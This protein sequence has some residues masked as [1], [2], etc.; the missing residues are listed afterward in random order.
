MV[1][2]HVGWMGPFLPEISRLASVSIDRAGLIISAASG[3]YFIALIA[4]G[5]M[6]HRHSAQTI[7]VVAMVLFSAGLAG[8][9]AAQGLPALLGAGVV[10]GL[11]NGAI[12]VAANA[13][14]VD[15]N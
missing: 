3:G 15:L 6:S 11:A 9:A 10:I 7:I 14:I 5:A 1:G 12:D 2:I 13:L 8:L 4:A